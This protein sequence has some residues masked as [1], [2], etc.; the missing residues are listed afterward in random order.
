MN[1]SNKFVSR[2]DSFKT[3]IQG[4]AANKSAEGLPIVC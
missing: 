3:G 4:S 1:Q 2:T